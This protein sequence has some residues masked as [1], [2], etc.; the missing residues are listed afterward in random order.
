MSR[1]ALYRHF[2]ANG[3]LLYVGVSFE[4]TRR[5]ADHSRNSGWSDRS[6][7]IE[8]EWFD[9][10]REAEAAERAAIR[11]EHPEFN[12]RHRDAVDP[13][14]GPFLCPEI[15][16]VVREIEGHCRDFGLKPTT[17]CQMGAGTRGLYAKMCRG[18]DLQYGTAIR[19]REWMAEDR[20][21]RCCTARAFR[22][23]GAA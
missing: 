7:R 12:I 14:E 22:S 5:A 15:E 13:A 10:R 3:R 17:V 19:L 9:S 20:N 2:D 6:S 4:P 8:M 11:D 1:A 21:S 23:G 16:A 18:G